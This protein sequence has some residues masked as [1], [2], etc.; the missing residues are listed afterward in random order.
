MSPSHLRRSTT[1]GKR[2]TAVALAIPLLL[3]VPATASQLIGTSDLK[4]G[5]VTTPKL[6]GAAVSAA[7]LKSGAVTTPK[8]R[9]RAVTTPKLRDGSVTGT[10][11]AP[12]AV[13]TSQL[14]DGAVRAGDLDPSLRVYSSPWQFG[15][16]ASAL[17]YD[18][19]A[20]TIKTIPAP[21]ITAS[22]LASGS[23]EVFYTFDNTFHTQLPYTS[24]AGG[25]PSTISFQA[26]VGAIRITRTSDDD[27]PPGI[28]GQ[29][30]YVVTPGTDAAGGEARTTGPA[31]GRSSVD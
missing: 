29:F 17:T 12:G 20:L 19:T 23:V 25:G 30:R 9:D 8:L 6:A 18:G 24:N 5:A 22:V 2:L 27:T 13:G 3:A 1:R 7:K 28:G 14:A 4:K 16:P 15:T 26:S 21:E 10:K 11:I 31:A